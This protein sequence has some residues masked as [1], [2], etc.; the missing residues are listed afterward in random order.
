MFSGP[1]PRDSRPGPLTPDGRPVGNFS[2]VMRIMESPDSV[3]FYY[4]IGQG[5]DS[6][7]WS[8]SRT[9]SRTA[10]LPQDVRQYWGDSIA[11]WDGDALVVDVTNF[12]H[13]TD[14]R[15]SREN[16]HLIERYQRVISKLCVSR[17]PPKIQP[18]G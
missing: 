10:H 5:S 2:G 9:R 13:E 3:D 18:L 11:H 12:T 6:I 4:D 8:R 15:G 14:F 17:L 7:G 1:P 16:L